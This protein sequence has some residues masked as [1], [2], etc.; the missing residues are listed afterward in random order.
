MEFVS[1]KISKPMLVI[2]F[3]YKY[4]QV[5]LTVYFCCSDRQQEVAPS[6]QPLIVRTLGPEVLGDAQ[7]SLTP[8]QL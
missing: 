2:D 6:R 1:F 4:M 5:K 7:G 8:R 3:K